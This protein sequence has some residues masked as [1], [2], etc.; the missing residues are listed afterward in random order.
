MQQWRQ[1]SAV[2]VGPADIK[3]ATDQRLAAKASQFPPLARALPSKPQISVLVW[4]E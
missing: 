1:D 2:P 4:R 3:A